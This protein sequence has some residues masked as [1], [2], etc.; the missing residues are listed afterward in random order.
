[1]FVTGGGNNRTGYSSKQ[2]DA[3]QAQAAAEPDPVKRAALL[4]QSEVLLVEKDV[5]I[6]PLYFSVGITLYHKNK[7]GGF[8][9]NQVDEHPI[10]ELY[11]K[12]KTSG[13]DAD[14]LPVPVAAP[15]NSPA[16]PAP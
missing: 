9:P 3:L 16:A 5:P 12:D 8:F 6:L 14:K 11:W 7:L 2:F 10:R 13:R 1:M 15:T 4:Y